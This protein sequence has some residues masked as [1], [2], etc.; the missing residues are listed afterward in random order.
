MF[1]NIVNAFLT[2]VSSILSVK[3]YLH[4]TTGGLSVDPV[5]ALTLSVSVAVV[6][7]VTFKFLLLSFPL[8]LRVTRSL[9]QPE[10][11]FEG[12][13]VM[14]I[15]ADKCV[16]EEFFYR[17]AVGKLSFNNGTLSY[18][19]EGRAFDDQGNPKGKWQSTNLTFDQKLSQF[20]Y[21]Y[22][23]EVYLEVI[24]QVK[25]AGILTFHEN[26]EGTYTEATDFFVEI[27]DS[28]GRYSC[29]AKKISRKTLKPYRRG[30]SFDYKALI[31]NYEGL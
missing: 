6:A 26:D 11:K 27:A 8:Y 1:A 16:G 7:T 31:E 28:I 2:T 30:A 13:W 3:L 25:G 17:Y 19:Y 20:R 14:K 5:S 29:F 23:G 12:T 9:L 24:K 15:H 4:L 22:E 18:G 10:A 21:F